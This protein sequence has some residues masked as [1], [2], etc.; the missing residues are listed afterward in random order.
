MS[1]VGAPK[2]SGK[3][4]R[5]T[6]SSWR[7]AIDISDITAGLEEKRAEE[8]VTGSTAASKKNEDLFMVDTTGDADIKPPPRPKKLLKSQQILAERSA[9]PAVFARPSSALP[10]AKKHL[11]QDQKDRLRRITRRDVKG[12]F[13]AVVD[14][15]PTHW[16]EGSAL[17]NGIQG[18]QEYD[19]WVEAGGLLKF[20]APVGEWD[21]PREFAHQ[22]KIKTPKSLQKGQLQSRPDVPAVPLPPTGQS[23][24]PTQAAHQELLRKAHETEVARLEEE[25]NNR[26]IKDRMLQARKDIREADGPSEEFVFGMQVDLPKDGDD[27]EEAEGSQAGEEEDS[28][29]KD[30]KRPERKTKQQRRK[31]DKVAADAAKRDLLV[32]SKHLTQTFRSLPS[33]RKSIDKSSTLRSQVIAARAEARDKK[34]RAGLAGVKV[35]KN[36]VGA[37]GEVDVQLGEELSDSFRGLKPEGNLFKDRFTSLQHR[38]LIEPRKPV[39]PKRRALAF[40]E[41][42]KHAWKRFE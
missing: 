7:K 32:Q 3:S 10:S 16:G 28:S 23:Y 31:A 22:K 29:W 6:K 36:V 21:G 25:A 27:E 26:A 42:E 11:T 20:D 37:G 4:S 39:Q 30:K 24:N 12:P 5:K 2:K 17:F 8:R 38:A 1:S 19:A 9:H 35:G 14:R 40:K 33:I 34:L 15:D 41:Y 18:G 13:G